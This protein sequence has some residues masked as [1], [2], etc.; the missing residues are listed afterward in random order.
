MGMQP[1]KNSHDM[2]ILI[3]R[4]QI[5]TFCTMHEYFICQNIS[6]L[7]QGISCGAFFDQ[8]GDAHDCLAFIQS[9]KKNDS[10]MKIIKQH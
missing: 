3:A 7:C 2:P 8:K 10:R 1:K 6:T 4:V 9:N 5:V